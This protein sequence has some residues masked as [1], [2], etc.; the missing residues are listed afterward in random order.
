MPRSALASLTN[1]LRMLRYSYLALPAAIALGFA[2]LAFLLL[3]LD[4]AAGRSGVG[5]LFPAG[6]PAARAVLTTIAGSLA[7]VVGVAFSVTIVTLQLV[8]Q[9]FTPRAVRGFLGDRVIQTVAGVF[10][11]VIVYCLV[12][13]RA[14]EEGEEPFVAGLT[15]TVAFALAVIALGMLLVF[16]HH[17]AQSI[18]AGEI[19]RKI[20]DAT[21]AAVAELYPESYG[22]PEL[23]NAD[24][25]VGEWAREAEPTIVVFPV[26]PGYVQAIGDIPAALKGER[27]RLELVVATGDF[28]TTRHPIARV[29]TDGDGDECARAIRRA[30]TIAAERDVH[31]D[32]GYGIRQLADIAVKALSPSVNDPTT[33]MTAVGYLQETFEQ[34]AGRA[35]PPRVRRV[36]DREVTLVMHRDPFEKLLE[37]LV[38]IGRYATDARIVEALLRACLRIR[39]A[40][41]ASGAHARAR[42]VARS[43]ERI[44]AR[45]VAGGS[46]DFTERA[47]IERLSRVLTGSGE[48]RQ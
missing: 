6:A 35:W 44:A 19:T 31:Q 26:E 37:P 30:V 22:Q 27:F 8:S 7:T 10:V 43:G 15:V 16:I 14:I 48:A 2:A 28:V 41:N 13:L 18:Q 33:A 36:P 3:A 17:V 29:W 46:L 23:E 11:G 25:I 5:G 9:Q 42:A 47:E 24:A 12:A 34:L 39:D 1:W 21:T 38:Q 4:A 45:A 32:V 40:A 20:A